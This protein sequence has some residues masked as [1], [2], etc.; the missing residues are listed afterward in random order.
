MESDEKDHWQGAMEKEINS[1]N[2]MGT[3]TLVLRP[4]GKRVIKG[5]WVFRIKRDSNG[6]VLQYKARYVAKGYAQQQG[7]DYFETY[8][9]VAKIKSLRFVFALA[10]QFN[11]ALHQVDIASAYLYG[12]L[13]EA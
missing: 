3:W 9:P 10:A 4:T 2:E 12:K 11:L 6:R 5:G 1:L 7:V 13:E 8:A